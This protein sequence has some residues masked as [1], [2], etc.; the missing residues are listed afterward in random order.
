MDLFNKSE[1]SDATEALLK[2]P[3]LELA[4]LNE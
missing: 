2:K 4:T 3:D 1:D